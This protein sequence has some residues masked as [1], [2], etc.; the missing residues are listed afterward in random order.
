MPSSATRLKS[1]TTP[2]LKTAMYKTH[3]DRQVVSGPLSSVRRHFHSVASGVV[4]HRIASHPSPQPEAQLEK[5]PIPIASFNY[6]CWP[7]RGFLSAGVL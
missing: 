6:M 5:R 2:P 1:L 7:A 3:F 4:L